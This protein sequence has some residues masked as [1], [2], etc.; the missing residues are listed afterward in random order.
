MLIS[1]KRKTD[2]YN[3]ISEPIM[4]NRIAISMSNSVLG[5][6]NIKDIE[7]MLYRLER[8]VWKKVCSALDIKDQ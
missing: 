2:L 4:N 7:E 1:E 3:A 8:Q 6:K 5:K